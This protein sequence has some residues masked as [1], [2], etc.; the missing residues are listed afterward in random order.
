MPKLSDRMLLRLI[1][2]H[3]DLDALL[4]AHPEVSRGDVDAVWRR[5]GLGE[6]DP[7][8]VD[9]DRFGASAPAQ[10][11]A[12]RRLV[13]RCDGAARG[14]PGPAAIGVLILDADGTPLRETG[15]RLGHATC[16]VAEYQAVIRAAEEALA[17]GA[18]ELTLLL[19]SELLVEQL[20]GAY[21]VRAAHLRPLYDRAQGLLRQFA[22]WDVRHVPREEN[23]AADALANRALDGP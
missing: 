13:A 20:R 11:A 16:N 9:R 8:P 12:G 14:N 23:A 2:E 17:L 6:P 1:R 19:D 22:R 7:R 21:K 5:L 3:L 18:T 15:A 10:G 4:A